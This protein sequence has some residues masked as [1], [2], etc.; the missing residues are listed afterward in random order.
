MQSD[1]RGGRICS[2]SDQILSSPPVNMHSARAKDGSKT[3]WKCSEVLRT[4][5]CVLICNK[6]GGEASDA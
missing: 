2:Q 3:S 4:C 1:V 5:L 6:A